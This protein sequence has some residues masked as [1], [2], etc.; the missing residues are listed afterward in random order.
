M[1]VI[2]TLAAFA[3]PCSL[4]AQRPTLSSASRAFVAVDAPVVALIH[5]RLM[6]G[7]G[8][9]AKDDQ[10]ILITGDKI[11]AVGK[12]GSVVIPGGA[13]TIDLTGRT[14]IPGIV[15]LHDHMYYSSPVSGSMK[16]M[17]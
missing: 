8:T 11:T 15:G 17:A 16:I 5:V 13:R 3:L 1:R 2:A 10:T 4:A 14:V 12:T 9:P 7:T 6:D